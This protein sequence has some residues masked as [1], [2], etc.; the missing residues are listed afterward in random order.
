M[1]RSYV[2]DWLIRKGGI[3]GFYGTCSPATSVVMNG[4]LSNPCAEFDGVSLEGKKEL[5]MSPNDQHH[6]YNARPLSGIWAQAPYLHNGSV[7]TVY[8]LLVPSERPTS[9]FKSRLEYDQEYLGFAWTAPPAAV[10]SAS[11][12]YVFDSKSFSAFSNLGHDTDV[13]ENGVRYKLD[14]S[15]DKAGAMAIIEY[16]KTL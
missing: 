4:V 6:G 12:G 14:W 5:I 15:A 8:H 2:V 3:V 13:E 11:R 9:F 10:E 7:P 1:E 16:L